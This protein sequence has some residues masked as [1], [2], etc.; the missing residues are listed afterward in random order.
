VNT[1][2]SPINKVAVN[3]SAGINGLPWNMDADENNAGV[4]VVN[5]GWAYPIAPGAT[6]SSSG[7]TFTGDQPTATLAYVNC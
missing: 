5:A 4:F 2:T 3:L 1:G 6:Y 7:Y